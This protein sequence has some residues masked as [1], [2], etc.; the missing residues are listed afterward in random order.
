MG[1]FKLIL[2]NFIVVL[3][4]LAFI[5]S[6]TQ[7]RIFYPHILPWFESPPRVIV[8]E[9]LVPGDAVKYWYHW[10]VEPRG[11]ILG[12][13][14]SE[15]VCMW[16]LSSVWD[17]CQSLVPRWLST[18]SLRCSESLAPAWASNTAVLHVPGGD[19]AKAWLLL[20]LHCAI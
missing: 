6:N 5:W 9:A 20:S 4:V 7:W 13:W 16:P 17:L 14:W 19:A 2:V 12:L 18:P 1:H 11:R 8:I 3:K 15:V 10:E